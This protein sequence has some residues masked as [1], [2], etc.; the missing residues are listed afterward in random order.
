MTHK[1]EDLTVIRAYELRD[2]KVFKLTGDGTAGSE[3][4][5]EKPNQPD[6]LSKQDTFLKAVRSRS[7]KA[8][9]KD[10]Q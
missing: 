9:E 1:G 3:V 10:P 7:R 5:S 2:G 8:Q 6:F 4:L